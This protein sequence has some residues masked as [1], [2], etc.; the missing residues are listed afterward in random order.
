MRKKAIVN[1]HNDDEECFKWSV[2]A[3]ENIGMKDPQHVSN[4]RKFKD[5][6]HWS[7]LE[8]PVSIKDIG[9]FEN[10]NNISVNVLAVE[11]RDIYIH[12]KGQR[13]G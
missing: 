8:L 12:R 2:I 6:Y 10:R 13:V 7:G 11:G 9:K 3:A 1:P 5:N 4:L